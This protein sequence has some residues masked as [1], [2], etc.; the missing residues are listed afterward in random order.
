MSALTKRPA[1]LN[2]TLLWVLLAAFSVQGAFPAGLEKK[3]TTIRN[4]TPANV[5]YLY[6]EADS[7]AGSVRRTLTPQA[8]DR[9]HCSSALDI[10]FDRNGLTVSYRLDCGQPFTFRLDENDEIE[11]YDGSHGIPDV[12]DLAPFVP[13]PMPVVNK[14][15]ELAKVGKNDILYDLGC[16]DGRIVIA[17]ARKYGTRGVG[18][19]IDPERIK[20]SK[21][22]AGKAGV[23][24]LVE[25]RQQDVMKADFSRATVV[26]LYLL[27]ESNELLRPVLEKQLKP[28]TYI[29]SHNYSIHGWEEKHVETVTVMDGLGEERTLFVYKR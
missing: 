15:L 26:T 25:F 12:P 20:E 7:S 11:L 22:A 27:P 19:D 21:E 16:G 2:T 8:V 1:F 3:E 9:I 29:V 13:T 24:H 18:I 28:G 10:S 6:Q 14:M 23:A 4:L 5:E 17:A